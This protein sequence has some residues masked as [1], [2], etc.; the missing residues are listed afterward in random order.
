[1]G[2][3]NGM[4]VGGFRLMGSGLWCGASSCESAAIFEYDFAYCKAPSPREGAT[5]RAGDRETNAQ[6]VIQHMWG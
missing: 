5:R 3:V 4:K 6:T 1:M 2:F